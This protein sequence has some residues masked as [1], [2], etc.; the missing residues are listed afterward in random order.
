MHFSSVSYR[1]GLNDQKAKI[2]KRDAITKKYNS[3]SRLVSLDNSLPFSFTKCSICRVYFQIRNRYVKLSP[4]IC[5]QLFL[6]IDRSELTV[7][8]TKKKNCGWPKKAFLYFK[9]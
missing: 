3:D 4:E 1:R 6:A 8:E 7:N 5:F 9:V 2:S